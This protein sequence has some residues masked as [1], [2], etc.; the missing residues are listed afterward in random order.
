MALPPHSRRRGD[1]SRLGWGMP[2]LP[3]ISTSPGVLVSLWVVYT[4]PAV[5]MAMLMVPALCVVR[6]R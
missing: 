3:A 6:D 1:G 4:I 5:G 2:S